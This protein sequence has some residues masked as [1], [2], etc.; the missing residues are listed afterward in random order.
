[1]FGKPLHAQ[2][3]VFSAFY[4]TKDVRNGIPGVLAKFCVI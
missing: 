4:S 2:K 3:N 1:M